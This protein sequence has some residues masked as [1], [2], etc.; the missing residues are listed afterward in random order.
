MRHAYKFV[1]LRCILL[2][3][4]LLRYGNTYSMKWSI[5]KFSIGCKV[6]YVNNISECFNNWL[7]D[8]KD[9][10]VAY[11]MHKI[12]EKIM[13][14]IYTRQD[15]ANRMEGRILGSVLDELNMKRRGLHYEFQRTSAM[16]AEI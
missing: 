9:L 5:S 4:L 3:T 8:Y 11:L 12:R 7:K 15:I 14:K 2:I 6:D 13:Q 16:S 10:Q 1:D